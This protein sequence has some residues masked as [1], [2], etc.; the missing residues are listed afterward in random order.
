MTPRVDPEEAAQAI[1]DLRNEPPLTE[2]GGAGC[3]LASLIV[4]VLLLG[5][6]VL[7]R[8]SPMTNE[9]IVRLAAA[10]GFVGLLSAVI[11]FTGGRNLA[12][13]LKGSCEEAADA[14]RAGL[15]QGQP[16]DQLAV[17]AVRILENCRLRR[18]DV[19][20]WAFPPSE[21]EVYLGD[22]WPYVIETEL[23]LLGKGLIS[24]TYTDGLGR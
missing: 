14:L 2:G 4:V 16:G 5:M 23:A 19:E 10:L 15:E 22:A 3:T 24:P 1:L 7:V 8:A 6:P 9:A 18:R 20:E 17:H 13:V 21:A 12:E 11:G